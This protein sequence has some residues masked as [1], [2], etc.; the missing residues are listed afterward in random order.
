MEVLHNVLQ[1]GHRR[2]L[3]TTRCRGVVNYGV[4]GAPPSPVP[5]SALQG[6]DAVLQRGQVRALREERQPLQG[7]GCGCVP[8]DLQAVPRRRH[9]RRQV[10]KHVRPLAPPAPPLGGSH[11][12]FQLVASLG[13]HEFG[14][15]QQSLAGLRRRGV[16]RGRAQRCWGV[17]P[18]HILMSLSVVNRMHHLRPSSVPQGLP[19]ARQ[20]LRR[21]H[22]PIRPGLPVA[23]DLAHAG[24]P[25]RG[26]GGGFEVVA[27]AEPQRGAAALLQAAPVGAILRI[28]LPA[29]S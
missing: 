23:G 3:I 16:G 26:P 11:P 9:R 1:R 20:A 17:R 28:L 27:H 29:K 24:L 8:C 22:S 6:Q 18:H 13:D 2:K 25:Q 19:L 4:H 14:I 10:Q 21:Q 5:D 12:D 7:G 15:A